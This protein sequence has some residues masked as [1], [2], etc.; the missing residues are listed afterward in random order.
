MAYPLPVPCDG[1]ATPVRAAVVA[2]AQA[3]ARQGPVP[4][5]ERTQT[6]LLTDGRTAEPRSTALRPVH[7]AG[8]P[9]PTNP[10]ET[11][12]L[13]RD[14]RRFWMSATF[15]KGAHTLVL[16]QLRL[17]RLPGAEGP[18]AAHQLARTARAL[19][20]ALRDV[21]AVY[22]LSDHGFAVL[23][24]GVSLRKGERVAKAM[25]GAIDGRAGK[26]PVPQIF[27]AGLAALHRDDDPVAILALA[28][29][30]LT[31]ARE[32]HGSAIVCETDNRIRTGTFGAEAAAAAS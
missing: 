21:G 31:L 9:P 23:G 18:E 29:R 14:L 8:A 32:S 4:L 19:Q 5:P 28:N 2:R 25:M 3:A 30:C 13:L 24:K 20:E 7:T 17:S 27:S 11:G 10:C 15:K 22:A 26:A 16:A 12:L 1:P 6:L